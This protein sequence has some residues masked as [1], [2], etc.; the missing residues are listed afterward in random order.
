MQLSIIKPDECSECGKPCLKECPNK[1]TNELNAFNCRHCPPGK[2]ECVL[3]CRKKAFVRVSQGIL[4]IDARKCDGCGACVKACSFQAIK[5]V[6]GKAGKCDLCY[7]A[8]FR[9]KCINACI[10]ENLVIEESELEVKEKER[11]IGWAAEK[12][13]A[14]FNKVVSG[15]EEREIIE[16]RNG[17][18]IYLL[19][20]LPELSVEEARIVDEVKQRFQRKSD[21]SRKALE[22]ELMDCLDEADAFIDEEQLD[23]LIK[24]VE[25]TV[26]GFGPLTKLLEDPELE[27]IALVGSGKESKARVFHRSFGW[28]KTN[29]FYCSEEEIKNLI[30][31]LA[32]QH[33][34]RITLQQ[35]CLNAWL[36]G[37]LR[38]H[39]VIQPVAF[40]G[41]CLTI[42]KFS[43][44]P[45]TL[46]DLICSGTISLEAAAFLWMALQ[47]DCNA[48]VCGNTGSGKTTTLNALF[49]CIPKNERIVVVEE[50][51]EISLP[52]E[53]LVKLN[54]VED[55][56]VSM[57][58]L[59]WSTLRMRP[60]RVIIG[61]ARTSE[62]ARAFVDTAL[63]GQGKG[64]Y[65]TF[66]A[67][68]GSEALNRLKSYGINEADLN[69]IDLVVVQKR[70]TMH[71]L[72]KNR[73]ADVRRIIE[74]SEATN[75]GGGVR[76]E[77]LFAFDYSRD[78]LKKTGKG[79]R[80]ARKIMQAFQLN[81]K[82]LNRELKDRKQKLLNARHLDAMG[83]FNVLSA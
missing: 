54:V 82:Q 19:K 13:K 10:K 28:L 79:N 2:A 4:G 80:I 72:K 64:S 45:I 76:A 61:E 75:E 60:D 21:S 73:K 78:S 37:N 23:Y 71:D 15:N 17:E 58:E 49:Y 33:G 83:L 36:E 12:L 44:K 52:H 50:T 46:V 67:Q 74:V 63:A 5:L 77:K 11:L 32:R 69:A 18:R 1:L 56:N 70:W 59:I 43:L 34:R 16:L 26:Y 35:P 55:I 53:H 41:S 3:A 57:Q 51:P 31:R 48:L 66:H 27:E 22:K 81:E 68:S 14:R 24:A 7:A 29:L 38:M 40:N 8:G 9:H 47:A 62:E 25:L 39:A 65:A 6:D 20:S 30:N 42:R